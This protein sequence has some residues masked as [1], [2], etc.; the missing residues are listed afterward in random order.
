METVIELSLEEVMEEEELARITAQQHAFE[1]LRNH[2]L[3][4]V[5]RLEE[6]ERQRQ[7]QKVRTLSIVYADDLFEYSCFAFWKTF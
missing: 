4:Q 3:K 7:L 5:K 6:H 2:K 1:E